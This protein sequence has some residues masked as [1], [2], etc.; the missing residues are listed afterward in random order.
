MVNDVVEHGLDVDALLGRDL[1]RVHGR[2]A[3]DVLDLG[4]GALGV[5]GGQVDLVDDRQDLEIVLERQ[6]GVGER[7]RLHAL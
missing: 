5:G 3:D 4:L 2:D 6:V 1:R 7:L